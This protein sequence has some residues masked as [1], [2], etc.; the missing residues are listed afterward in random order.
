LDL[1]VFLE[2]SLV[3]VVLRLKSLR[4]VFLELCHF[5]L[6]EVD[7]FIVNTSGLHAPPLVNHTFGCFK[8]Y[9][10]FVYLSLHLLGFFDQFQLIVVLE[11]FSVAD[12]LVP[13]SVH[14]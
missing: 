4:K 6:Q 14:I 3:E 10:K 8:L 12:V 9:P 5:P 2:Q 1:A 11:M 13:Q 7:L